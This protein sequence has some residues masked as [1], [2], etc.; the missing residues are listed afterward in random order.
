MAQDQI[1]LGPNVRI[2]QCAHAHISQRP[3]SDALDGGKGRQGRPT[4]SMGPQNDPTFG[5]L[6][7]DGRQGP[8]P[9]L[10]EAERLRERIRVSG[11]QHGW[12][13]K[14]RAVAHV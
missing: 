9:G 13:R 2:A 10:R 12:A 14:A 8:R 1:T 6:R 3:G 4:V 11:R 5:D 7:R